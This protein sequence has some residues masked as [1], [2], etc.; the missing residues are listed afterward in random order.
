MYQYGALKGCNMY[1]YGAL[2]GMQY[3]SIWRAKRDA[4][5]INMAR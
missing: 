5:C 4:I 2:K 1:Q 3:V